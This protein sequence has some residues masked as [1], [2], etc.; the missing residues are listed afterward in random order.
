MRY[1]LYLAVR[2]AVLQVEPDFVL[3]V[4]NTLVDATRMARSEHNGGR[5]WTIA[6]IGEASRQLKPGVL[7]S[8]DKQF[9]NN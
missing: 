3:V 8:R 1:G 5:G 9:Q 7:L 4:A 2:D 6:E